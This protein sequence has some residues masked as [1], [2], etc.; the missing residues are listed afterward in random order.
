MA[1]I[2]RL[3]LC[4]ESIG[5]CSFMRVYTVWKKTYW[6]KGVRRNDRHVFVFDNTSKQLYT[7]SS[8]QFDRHFRLIKPEDMEPNLW[9]KIQNKNRA[10]CEKKKGL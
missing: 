8:E 6:K 5:S 2:T 9:K 10:E 1:H 4:L 7:F 3:A